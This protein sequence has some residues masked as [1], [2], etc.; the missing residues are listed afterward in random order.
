MTDDDGNKVKA[1]I[2]NAPEPEDII[3]SNLGIDKWQLRW[4]KLKTFLATVLLLAISLAVT[5][6][7][8]KAQ[9]DSASNKNNSYLSILI[10]LAISIINVIIQR[11]NVPI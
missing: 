1:Y 8:S 7:L 10:S 11:T 6:G 3:W 2:K 5:F 9:I 4:K